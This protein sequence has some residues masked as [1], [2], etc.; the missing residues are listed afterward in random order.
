MPVVSLHQVAE[1]KRV[2]HDT[3]YIKELEIQPGTRTRLCNDA[4]LCMG[5]VE[6]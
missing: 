4:C 6:G 3:A 1:G 2:F 5:D